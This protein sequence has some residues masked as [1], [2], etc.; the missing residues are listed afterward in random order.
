M[1]KNVGLEVW[2][3]VD[4]EIHYCHDDDGIIEPESMK[5]KTLIFF[6]INLTNINRIKS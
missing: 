3:T 6:L 4:I 2:S 1:E 5:R